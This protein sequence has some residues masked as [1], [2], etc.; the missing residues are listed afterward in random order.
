MLSINGPAKRRTFL[1]GDEMNGSGNGLL[2][3]LRFRK[4]SG[5]VKEILSVIHMSCYDIFTMKTYFTHMAKNEFA[6]NCVLDIELCCVSPS[7]S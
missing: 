6:E 7:N 4:A 5:Y 3:S 2:L 1:Y